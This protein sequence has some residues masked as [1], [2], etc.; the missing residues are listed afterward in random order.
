MNRY[1]QNIDIN[2]VKQIV[3]INFCCLNIAVKLKFW[4]ANPTLYLM[5]SNRDQFSDLISKS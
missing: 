3:K 5:L 1:S 2:Y 4:Q